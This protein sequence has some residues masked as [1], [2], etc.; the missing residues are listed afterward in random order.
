MSAMRTPRDW[1]KRA[2]N[3]RRAGRRGRESQSPATATN[4][5]RWLLTFVEA[6]EPRP[7]VGPLGCGLHRARE[8]EG[9]YVTSAM[10]RIRAK[11]LPLIKARPGLFLITGGRGLGKSL[12]MR[13]LAEE[14]RAT[15][16]LAV[17]IDRP[18]VALDELLHTI[19]A[20]MRLP[21][22]AE[23]VAKWLG[24][25]RGVL[26]MRAEGRAPILLLG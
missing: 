8:S 25:V 13:W 14:L 19:C 9:F 3:N 12:F 17:S 24:Q 26:A 15:G 4:G 5:Q 16:H 2:T 22:P 1:R 20:E 6:Q 18:D 21:L 23:D 7:I 10:Q 11:L